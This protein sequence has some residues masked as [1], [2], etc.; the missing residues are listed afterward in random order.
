MRRWP[1]GSI[2]APGWPRAESELTGSAGRL[3]RG[4]D[5]A[6]DRYAVA[7]ARYESLSAGDFEA[8]LA[9]VLAEVGLEAG[10]RSGGMWLAVGRSRGSGGP[11]CHHAV[12]I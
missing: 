11:G 5:G 7:L 8:R 10:L 2:G 12:S 1:S 3:G 6:N 9:T 4:D